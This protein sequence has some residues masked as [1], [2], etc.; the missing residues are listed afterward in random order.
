M[1]TRVQNLPK[2]ADLIT[3][4]STTQQIVD[5]TIHNITLQS[6]HP[7]LEAI[8]VYIQSFSKNTQ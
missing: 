2:R 1:I 8:A 6:Y 7:L 5:D 3:V 4:M